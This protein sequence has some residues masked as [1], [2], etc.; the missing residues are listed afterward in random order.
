MTT[1]DID[2]LLHMSTYQGMTDEEIQLVIDT[3]CEMAR[4]DAIASVS[5]DLYKEMESRI[6]EDHKRTLALTEAAFNSVIES[7]VKFQT[8]AEVNN[9]G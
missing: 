8:I 5:T 4:K 3:K 2:E 7:S 9:N 6:L 1:R